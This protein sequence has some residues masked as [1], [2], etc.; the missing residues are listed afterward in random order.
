[1]Q[2]EARPGEVVRAAA[3]G[4]VIGFGIGIFGGL[5]SVLS[6]HYIDYGL[7]RLAVLTLEQSLTANVL[8]FI[9]LSPLVYGLWWVLSK[10]W[11]IDRTRCMRF[12][13]WPSSR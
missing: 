11:A 4:V 10:R 7:L 12:G 5:V 6:N 8:V 1:M 13:P 9:L 3:I 2:R